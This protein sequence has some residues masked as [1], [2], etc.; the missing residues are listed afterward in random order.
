MPGLLAPV[1]GP[2]RV[3]NAP[4]EL[5]GDALG[6]SRLAPV[7]LEELT[8][9][10]SLQTRVDRKYLLP[11]P[12]ASALVQELGRAARVL[13]IES[14]RTFGYESVY[15]DTPGLVCFRR[16]AHKRP[17][18]FKVRTRT[19]LDSG[20]CWLE[21]KTRDRRGRTVKQ[22]LEYD[23]R[24]RTVLTDAGLAFVR[25]ALASTVATDAA[26]GIG[27]LVPTLVT[28]YRRSTLLLPAD[29]SRL[30]IDTDLVCLQ[31]ER[32]GGLRMPSRAVVETKTAGH[33]SDVDRLL[34]R[35]GVRPVQI[36]K[37]GTGM[38]AL[39]PELPGVKWRPVL[40]R[41]PFVPA[42]RGSSAP[43]V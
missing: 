40:R 17:T 30:T 33:A 29:D 3:P 21:V 32:L 37:Y 31:D 10:A 15:F 43:G 4:S 6:L 9:R 34:W 14:R 22:R 28:R 35:R 41:H 12:D 27:T 26:D 1:E 23:G 25:D 2:A 5:A 36:S 39:H 7:R 38:A 11:L 19:Y 13:E 20:D 18:R 24:D 8:Q 16:A 42:G